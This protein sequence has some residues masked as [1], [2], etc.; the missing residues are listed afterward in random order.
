MTV[1]D[2]ACLQLIMVALFQRERYIST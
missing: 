1:T 2:T